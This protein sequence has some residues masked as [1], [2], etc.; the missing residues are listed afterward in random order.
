MENIAWLPLTPADLDAVCAVAGRAH[1][2]LPERPEVFAEKL[3]LFPGGCFKLALGVTVT[4]YALMHPWPAGS[5]PKLDA[6]IGALPPDAGVLYLH[7][8]AMLPEARGRGA[9]RAIVDIA[10][11]L[12][13]SR[14]LAGLALVS[15]HGTAALW[16]RLGFRRAA[17][18][19]LSSYGGTAVYMTRGL[20]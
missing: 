11:K 1:A 15:V 16:E 13:R 18:P 14:G 10:A 6:F 20:L 7:D 3:R 12:A 4:G 2:D 19:D 5:A 17:G 8:V 9:A